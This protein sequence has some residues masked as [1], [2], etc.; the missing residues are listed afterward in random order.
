MPDIGIGRPRRPALWYAELIL[1]AAIVMI[2][3]CALFSSAAP[4]GQ[5]YHSAEVGR[6]WPV[7]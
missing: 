5:T 2:G 1:I 6:G 3:G 4:H 7:S